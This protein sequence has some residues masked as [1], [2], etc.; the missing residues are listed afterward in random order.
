MLSI[1]QLSD[2]GKSQELE[3]MSIDD[4]ISGD[5]LTSQK[6]WIDLTTEDHEIIK[7]LLTELNIDHLAIEDTLRKSHP[8]KIEFFDEHLFILYRGIRAIEDD[9]SFQ[10][11]SIGLIVKDNILVTVHPVKSVGVEQSKKALRKLKHI[12]PMT[13]AIQIMKAA[14]SVYLEKLLNFDTQLSEIEE[15][16]ENNANDQQLKE[17][18]KFKSRL[19]KLT[20]TFNYHTDI[21]EG[22]HKESDEYAYF[23]KAACEHAINDLDDRFQRLFTL[24]QMHYDIC[25]DL[26]DG[27]LS[28]SAHQLNETMRVLTV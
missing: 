27:Y 9:I 7:R 22:L 25:G 16:L 10:H 17:L 24:A 15:Q 21:S 26:I 6:L 14:S 28:I 20:R 8:S 23:D 5:L 2:D 4:L 18:T 1:I 12:S 13:V 19:V 3:A 11:Q